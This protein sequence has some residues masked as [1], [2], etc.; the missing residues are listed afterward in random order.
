[1]KET[2]GV[3][4]PIG[5]NGE[6]E[7]NKRSSYNRR[8]VTDV[9]LSTPSQDAEKETLQ[10]MNFIDESARHMIGLMKGLKAYDAQDVKAA[11][12]CAQV[13]CNLMSVRQKAIK[14]IL[15]MDGR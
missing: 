9:A 10:S 13:V 3:S 4:L 12:Q 6:K 8:P 1:M 11:C 7:T 15:D 2:M 5:A 14:M